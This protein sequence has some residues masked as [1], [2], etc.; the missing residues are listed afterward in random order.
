MRTSCEHDWIVIVPDPQDR[1]ERGVQQCTRCPV[2]VERIHP[3]PVFLE[4]SADL[5]LDDVDVLC[6]VFGPIAAG[7]VRR[8]QPR[9]DLAPTF[10]EPS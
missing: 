4:P 9:R 1:P 3:V 5:F 7:V 6:D 10:L 8:R 2:E